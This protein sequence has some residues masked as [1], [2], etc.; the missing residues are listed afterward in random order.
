MYLLLCNHVW[1]LCGHS[2]LEYVLN[3]I[4]A[5]WPKWTHSR[6][7]KHA[8]TLSN[9]SEGLWEGIATKKVHVYIWKCCRIRAQRLLLGRRCSRTFLLRATS[10]V[11]LVNI[12]FCFLI[13]YDRICFSIEIP[14]QKCAGCQTSCEQQKSYGKNPARGK[15]CMETGVSVKD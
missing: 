13:F 4:F 15:T 6:P 11:I 7:C 3:H 14:F 5:C 1:T 9:G 8:C 2:I 12:L 10:R